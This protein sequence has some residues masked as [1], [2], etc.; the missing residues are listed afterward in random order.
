M[1]KEGWLIRQNAVLNKMTVPM[2]ITCLICLRFVEIFL[3]LDLQSFSELYQFVLVDSSLTQGWACK[4]ICYLK[5][6]PMI[7]I[8][9]IVNL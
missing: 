6:I 4:R 1:I 9:G 5:T 2:N 7:S 3:L 8:L